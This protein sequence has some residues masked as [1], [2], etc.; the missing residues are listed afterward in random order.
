LTIEL[1][2]EPLEYPRRTRTDHV[3]VLIPAYNEAEAIGTVVLS[4][5]ERAPGLTVIVV[6][7]GS[8]DGTGEI[9]TQTGALVIRHS[10]NR[11]YGAAL[12]TGIRA[13]RT[14]LVATYDADGQHNPDDLLRMLEASDGA[15]ALIGARQ[16]DSYR[17]VSRRPGKWLLAKV[18]NSLVGQRIPDL[19]CGLRVMRREVVSRYLHLLPNGFSASTTTTVCMV[20]RGYDVRFVPI[21]ASRRI[22]KSSVRQVRDGLNTVLLIVRLIVMFNPLRFFLP[23]AAGLILLGA[24]YGFVRAW[25]SGL[26]IPV[27]S[28]L[29]I[30]AGMITAMFGLL[31]DQ[32]SSLRKEM[33][34]KNDP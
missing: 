16:G 28:A 32:L 14:A 25:Q 18:A 10:V 11:G 26:G 23:P 15:D 27:L 20:Q 2:A 6:D 13:A 1:K 29:L 12:K 19:N 17:Q 31:A 21:K 22:G 8:S 4:L 9:A 3:T 34:E 5:R 7:D 30:V 33:F 24:V